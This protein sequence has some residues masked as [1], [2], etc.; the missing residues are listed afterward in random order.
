MLPQELALESVA[1]LASHRRYVERI[2]LNR[3]ILDGLLRPAMNPG[4]PGVGGPVCAVRVIRP[5][6]GR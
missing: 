2:I 1:L 6:S 4:D 3:G 5:D